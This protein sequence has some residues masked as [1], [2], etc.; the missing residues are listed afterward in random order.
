MEPKHSNFSLQDNTFHFQINNPEMEVEEN[1]HKI[2]HVSNKVL[3]KRKPESELLPS[4]SKNRHITIESK[5]RKPASLETSLDRSHDKR[6]DKKIKTMMETKVSSD[7]FRMIE[8]WKT[9]ELEKQILTHID[10]AI[11]HN[12]VK[13][14]TQKTFEYQANDTPLYFQISYAGDIEALDKLI[15]LKVDFPQDPQQVIL[16]ETIHGEESCENASKRVEK[17]LFENF[18][19]IVNEVRIQGYWKLPSQLQ[20]QISSFQKICGF[21]QSPAKKEK[22]VERNKKLFSD[23]HDLLE[24][25]C[26][27]KIKEIGSCIKK[28]GKP[29]RSPVWLSILRELENGIDVTEVEIFFEDGLAVMPL[30][31]TKKKYLSLIEALYSS[32][33]MDRTS[34]RTI[35]RFSDH[36]LEDNLA[37]KKYCKEIEYGLLSSQIRPRET[38]E[39]NFWEDLAFNWKKRTKSDFSQI[40]TVKRILKK[41]RSSE[42]LVLA[43]EIQK[44]ATFREDINQ[45]DY[46]HFIM[47]NQ[48]SGRGTLLNLPTGFGKTFIIFMAAAQQIKSIG[49]ENK[50]PYLVIVPANNVTQS[51]IDNHKLLTQDLGTKV[52]PIFP[53]KNSLVPFDSSEKFLAAY[54]KPAFLDID[55]IVMTK[56]LLSSIVKS[57]LLLKTSDLSA[58]H[59]SLL[60]CLGILSQDNFILGDPSSWKKR[61][62]AL[63]SWNYQ[64]E[65]LELLQEV[66]K[67]EHWCRNGL[68]DVFYPTGRKSELNK[69]ELDNKRKAFISGFEAVCKQHADVADR[70]PEDFLPKISSFNEEGERCID[71]KKLFDYCQ[72]FFFFKQSQKKGDVLLQDLLNE[73]SPILVRMSEEQ[74]ILLK[75]YDEF[76]SSFNG[77]IL[78][79]SDQILVVT[80]GGEVS[81]QTDILLDIAKTF[82]TR[83]KKDNPQNPLLIA[84]SATPWPNAMNELKLHLKFLLPKILGQF[85]DLHDDLFGKWNSFEASLDR[86]YAFKSSKLSAD[87]TDEKTPF[88][89]KSQEGALNALADNLN[90]VQTHFYQWVRLLFEET[91]SYEKPIAGQTNNST[92]EI[93]YV[94]SEGSSHMPA[95]KETFSLIKNFYSGL[96]QPNSPGQQRNLL[97]QIFEHL[98]GEDH[99]AFFVELQEDAAYLAMQISDYY[100][101]QFDEGVQIGLFYDETFV[102][103][104]KEVKKTYENI[105]FNTDRM[106]NINSF[107]NIFRFED[108]YK[109]LDYKYFNELS[110]NKIK[111]A[112]PPLVYLIRCIQE[113]ENPR[114]EALNGKNPLVKMRKLIE[115]NRNKKK[116][117][118]TSLTKQE[119][120]LYNI[121]ERLIGLEKRSK[122]QII[123]NFSKELEIFKPFIGKELQKKNA[124]DAFKKYSADAMKKIKQ[125][126]KKT[127][128]DPIEDLKTAIFHYL[129]KIHQSKILIYGNAGTSGMRIDA[130]SLTVLSGAW[131][132]GKLSQIKGRVGR[133][134]GAGNSRQCKIYLPITSTRFEFFILRYYIKKALYNLFIT[135]KEYIG[136]KALCQHLF[137]SGSLFAYYN[138]CNSEEGKDVS[139][140]DPSI[141]QTIKERIKQSQEYLTLGAYEKALTIIPQEI[142]NELQEFEQEIL[143]SPKL[144]RIQPGQGGSSIEELMPDASE[145]EAESSDERYAGELDTLTSNRATTKSNNSNKPEHP[146][147]IEPDLNAAWSVEELERVKK[148]VLQSKKEKVIIFLLPTR[149]EQPDIPLLEFT[150]YVRDSVE[151]DCYPIVIYGVNHSAG[152][153]RKIESS[154]P[155]SLNLFAK[156]TAFTWFEEDRNDK[157]PPIGQMRNFCLEQA[158]RVWEALT[159]GDYPV[160]DKKA[161]YLISMDGDTQLTSKSFQQMMKQVHHQDSQPYVVATGGY[162]F[163]SEASDWSK[164][165]NRIGMQINHGCQAEVKPLHTYY[166]Y[167]AEPLTAISPSLLQRLF[168]QKREKSFFEM[169]KQEEAPFGF[170]N[171]EGRRLQRYLNNLVGRKLNSFGPPPVSQERPILKNYARFTVEAPQ[172][173]L[174]Q[175]LSKENMVA[176]I[177]RL[178][179][180]PQHSIRP[181]FMASN[182]AYHH[183][184]KSAPVRRFA[185]F[186]Y[187]KNILNL[188]NL[189]PERGCAFTKKVSNFYRNQPLEYNEEDCKKFGVGKE[190]FISF[191]KKNFGERQ[192]DPTAEEPSQKACKDFKKYAI[193]LSFWARNVF[194]VLGA[195]FG[196]TYSGERD[197]K[198]RYIS[199][200]L[201]ED[202]PREAESG[203]EED[204]EL[205]A[206]EISSKN[207]RTISEEASHR[208]NRDEQLSQKQSKNSLTALSFAD[209]ER[210]LA[211]NYRLTPIDMQD[212]TCI[213]ELKYYP[214]IQKIVIIAKHNLL[215]LLLEQTSS[216]LADQKKLC[217]ETLKKVKEVFESQD[218]LAISLHHSDKGDVVSYAQLKEGGLSYTNRWDNGKGLT[219]DE[220]AIKVQTNSLNSSSK[221]GPIGLCNLGVSC[222]MNASL[223]VI[224]NIPDICEKIRQKKNDN[225]ITKRLYSLLPENRGLDS[226]KNGGR[227]ELQLLLKAI[228]SKK[229]EDELREGIKQQHDPREFLQIIFRI[230]DWLPLN[231]STVLYADA[232]PS[233]VPEQT[234]LISV[235][236]PETAE[237]KHF[238]VIIS[239]HFNLEDLS[240]ITKTQ[241]IMQ[242]ITGCSSH[243]IV[244]L[245]RFNNFNQKIDTD[246]IF[247]ENEIMYIPFENKKLISFEIVGFINHMGEAVHEGHYTSYV[248]MDVNGLKQWFYCDDNVVTM[249]NPNA[250]IIHS[251]G[252]TENPEIFKNAYLIILKP[253]DK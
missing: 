100:Q 43:P 4:S 169:E 127:E 219:F 52:D 57:L 224:F 145:L 155:E 194:S 108:F 15:L 104:P 129:N 68:R 107:N 131:T 166:G 251:N 211:K 12:T 10:Y 229:D 13:E 153:E 77:L 80:K 89:K 66:L 44:L 119:Q 47:R 2:N 180:Q 113:K 75:K 40:E 30:S 242:N 148:Q 122:A 141:H 165:S 20:Q 215:I 60:R 79:E 37:I 5:K 175:Q 187:A 118:T 214:E 167:L 130:D 188:L 253:L 213:E 178:S 232:L 205:L 42:T 62:M 247:P 36:H 237:K 218:E 83:S 217:Q 248:K 73:L 230:L 222:Y 221:N 163:A 157:V 179:L 98:N 198:G 117:A 76:K 170:W 225:D 146:P 48:R 31:L 125:R 51:W 91:V 23:D 136:A 54:E 90:T 171:F 235:G 241:T 53:N 25:F 234:N 250:E 197:L 72:C 181:Y 231:T 33:W 227:S 67:N 208:K 78:D 164:Q 128:H 137:L 65:V 32:S 112:I 182:I 22:V 158:M 28:G 3:M 103:K 186:F 115:K 101:Q 63:N 159:A 29:P 17:L 69:N 123:K 152:V 212:P 18:E 96:L 105:T 160:K 200:A 11:Q 144:Q 46:V 6:N 24:R 162:E 97:T 174:K 138:R 39:L 246:I 199:M 99:F 172:F 16:L 195:E 193:L 50:K 111:S 134:K 192:A 93:L 168:E 82:Q 233:Q 38:G 228:F 55:F 88:S 236:I 70:F 35:I 209:I 95:G 59:E 81:E 1:N 102:R 191:L 74:K 94:S 34:D 121:F 189:G 149:G 133:L 87:Q 21:S 252:K 84:S 64:T 86:M 45:A 223:Q 245:K 204:E 140:L 109:Y 114:K 240:D 139:F 238:Q 120:D 249:K 154:L 147:R 8:S 14:L 184:Q 85:R 106:V 156:I 177:T 243:L 56:K 176:V 132:E 26:T 27:L 49:K 183:Q 19:T 244:H 142:R 216:K 210:N 161:I 61:I 202:Y 190:E 173:S 239:D 135:S 143:A 71:S 92:E 116:P 206:A 226:K 110:I 185:S 124:V 207:N 9:P 220:E 150:G 41:D 58:T 201:P 7:L 126:D 203:V 196:D 151:A